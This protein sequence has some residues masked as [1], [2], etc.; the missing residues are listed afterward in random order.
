MYY[1]KAD[2][3]YPHLYEPIISKELFDNV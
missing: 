3:Y 1:K 2:K